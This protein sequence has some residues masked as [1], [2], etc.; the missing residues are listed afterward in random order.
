MLTD[1]RLLIETPTILDEVPLIEQFLDTESVL[2]LERAHIF[3]YFYFYFK[4]ARSLFAL[5]FLLFCTRKHAGDT[6]SVIQTDISIN[7]GL[8]RISFPVWTVRGDDRGRRPSQQTSGG[9]KNVVSHPV[10]RCISL[11]HMQKWFFSGV[12]TLYIGTSADFWV[13]TCIHALSDRNTSCRV[14]WH[15]G[16]EYRLSFSAPVKPTPPFICTSSNS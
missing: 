16:P 12:V 6:S 11:Y 3:V 4:Y 9:V 7:C 2:E 5:F 1:F 14:S 10:E 8:S 15:L 13:V